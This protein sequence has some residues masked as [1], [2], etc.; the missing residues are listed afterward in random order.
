MAD[1]IKNS[2]PYKILREIKNLSVDEA[3]YFFIRI[4]MCTASIYD[5]LQDEKLGI[6]TGQ[7]ISKEDHSLHKDMSPSIPTPYPILRKVF[8]RLRLGP[9]DIFVD[10]GCGKG[11]AVFMAG[12]KNI[13]KAVGIELNGDII[14]I[15][16]DNLRSIKTP[17]AAVEFV[18]GDAASVSLNEG[19]VFFMYNPFGYKTLSKVMNNI[20]A[21]LADKPRRIRIAYYS[22]VHRELFDSG[23]WLKEESVLDGVDTV[24]WTNRA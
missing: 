3:R 18:R 19:T 12:A 15:A 21:S 20:K 8:D 6:E 16:L 17:L 10:I 14:A 9:Q 1:F 4:R 23:D 11:R 5:I 7:F 24:I 2:L 13:K 22:P